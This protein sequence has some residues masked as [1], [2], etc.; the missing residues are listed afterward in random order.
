[1]IRDGQTYPV[2]TEAPFPP[3][4]KFRFL[5]KFHIKFWFERVDPAA[6]L[7]LRQF[8]YSRWKRWIIQI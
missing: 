3:E 4:P 7:D 5:S 6:H 8:S 2:P 1:M